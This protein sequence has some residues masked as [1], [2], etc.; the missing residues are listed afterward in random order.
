MITRVLI[1]GSNVVARQLLMDLM[2]QMGGMMQH[3]GEVLASGQMAPGRIKQMGDVMKQMGSLM[4]GMGGMGG[5]SMGPMP[6]PVP[7]MAKMM[8]PMTGRR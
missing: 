3:L 7:E 4:G 1:R 2:Q 5:G 8:E 6:M